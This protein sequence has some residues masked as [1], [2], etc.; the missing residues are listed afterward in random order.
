MG[1]KKY[2]RD[3]YMILEM[4]MEMKKK[5]YTLA[6]IGWEYLSNTN[7]LGKSCTTDHNVNNVNCHFLISIVLH[8]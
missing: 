6:T 5:N 8:A 7:S 3:I 2:M 1:K 4:D